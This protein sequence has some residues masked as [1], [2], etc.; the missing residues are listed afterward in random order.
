MEFTKTQLRIV[1]V[2]SDGKRHHSLELQMYLRKHEPEG[3]AKHKS[4]IVHI[5]GIRKK[6]RPVGE[7][8]VCEYFQRKKYYRHVRLL[9]GSGE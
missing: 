3:I 1:E 6:L 2:L 9:A 4:V 5:T 8:I 7:D